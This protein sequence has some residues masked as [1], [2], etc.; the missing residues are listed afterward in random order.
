M[1]EEKN[2]TKTMQMGLG[3]AVR[4]L[5]D[6]EMRY[7]KGDMSQ[8]LYEER[9]LLIEALNRLQLDL[10][11]D[12]DDDG[13]PDTVEI[14]EKSAKTSCCRIIPTKGKKGAD[15]RRVKGSSRTNKTKKTK[16][17]RG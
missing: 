17:S 14:F 4:R 10:G 3:T 2:N 8:G 7:R 1:S 6:V 11:F 12:C 15:A 5:L 9:A 13:V 16:S